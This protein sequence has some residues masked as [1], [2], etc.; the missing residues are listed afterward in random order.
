MASK[1]VNTCT[2]FKNNNPLHFVTHLLQKLTNLKI[3]FQSLYI[4]VG[5]L[6]L[7]YLKIVFLMLSVLF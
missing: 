3:I 4:E 1:W 6:I 7:K 5:I 2:V